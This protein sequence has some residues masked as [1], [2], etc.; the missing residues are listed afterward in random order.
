[1]INPWDSKPILSIFC[2]VVPI[3]PKK[4]QSSSSFPDFFEFSSGQRVINRLVPLSIP[5]RINTLIYILSSIEICQSRN[6]ASK[7]VAIHR[8]MECCSAYCSLLSTM[9]FFIPPLYSISA[10]VSVYVYRPNM[11][12]LCLIVWAYSA[13]C[14]KYPSYR[15]KGSRLCLLT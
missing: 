12:K 8:F 2:L 6:D 4:F 9:C 14:L 7:I 15:Q 1:M 11:S 13:H 3:S 10:L 5:F